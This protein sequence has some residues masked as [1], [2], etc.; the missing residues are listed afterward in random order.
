MIGG[1]TTS[2]LHTALKI[3]PVYDAPV[4][5]MKDASQNALVAARL[6]NEK[7]APSYIKELNEQHES[8]RKKMDTN[9]KPLTPLNEA[10]EKGLKLF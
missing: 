1:A 6:L 7:E 5:W 3:A 8:L 9:N 2:A 10:R 4:V